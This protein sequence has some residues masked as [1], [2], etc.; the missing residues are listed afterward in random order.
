MEAVD[1]QHQI[2]QARDDAIDSASSDPAAPRRRTHHLRF[3]SAGM[4][5]GQSIAEKDRDKQLRMAARR[6][7]AYV[8]VTDPGAG[9]PPGYLEH[10]K[11]ARMLAAM[12]YKVGMGIGKEPGIRIPVERPRPPKAGLGGI[13][14]GSGSTAD[15]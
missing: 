13:Q 1:H 9:L 7:L 2:G 15:C 5:H 6:R 12:G 3:V 11:G 10:S 14:V 8:E 4:W